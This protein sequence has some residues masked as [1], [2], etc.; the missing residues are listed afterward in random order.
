MR[1][2][3]PLDHDLM[4]DALCSVGAGTMGALEQLVSQRDDRPWA[5]REI[6]RALISLGHL[7]VELDPQMTPRSWSISP[8]V[9]VEFSEGAFLAGW[10]SPQLLLALGLAANVAGGRVERT[11]QANGPSRVALL[12]VDGGALE[13]IASRVSESMGVSVEVVSDAPS[14]LASALS[15]LPTLR[16]GLPSIAP[17]PIGARLER[18]DVESLR[19]VIASWQGRPGA[20]RTTDRPRVIMHADG[21]DVRRAEAR[22]AKWLAAGRTPLLA[23][24]RRRERAICHMGTEPPGLYERA[25][26]LCSGLLPSPVEGHLVEYTKVGVEVASAVASRLSARVGVNV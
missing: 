15:S 19:W 22:L 17:P 21:R 7:D 26:V 23:H 20:Y 18:L 25:L 16:G 5:S 12:D 3:E 14:R 10:R 4:L 2:E 13:R 24:D 1:D 8:S 6:A 9:L 11:A